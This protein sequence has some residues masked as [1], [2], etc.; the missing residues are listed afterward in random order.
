MNENN[1][2]SEYALSLTKTIDDAVKD[3]ETIFEDITKKGDS[4][5]S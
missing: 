3:F 1:N 4:N 5:D 2:V